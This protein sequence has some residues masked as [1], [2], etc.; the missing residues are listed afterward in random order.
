MYRSELREVHELRVTRLLTHPQREDKTSFCFS[1]Q[2]V[3]CSL[4]PFFQCTTVPKEDEVTRSL[5]PP[6][7]GSPRFEL[8]SSAYL[9]RVRSELFSAK[10]SLSPRP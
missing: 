4:I 1:G 5:A 9:Y 2:H 7:H 10:I 8:Q 6:S 3:V